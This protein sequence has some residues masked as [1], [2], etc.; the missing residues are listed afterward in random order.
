MNFWPFLPLARLNLGGLCSTL[1]YIATFLTNLPVCY[2]MGASRALSRSPTRI[3][4]LVYH[5]VV[6]RVSWIE[7]FAAL[8]DKMQP[9][10]SWVRCR[11]F[12]LVVLLMCIT[13]RMLWGVYLTV[14]TL[15]L[16]A[17]SSTRCACGFVSLIPI[18]SVGSF[19]SVGRLLESRSE[20]NWC[21]SL[22][23]ADRIQQP[24]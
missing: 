19:M 18:V 13:W 6:E 11:Y 15:V 2:Q 12:L 14:L 22:W 23:Q 16:F 21:C 8:E 3:R 4:S 1:V 17:L 7:L 20:D 10:H 24:S 5:P 9:C